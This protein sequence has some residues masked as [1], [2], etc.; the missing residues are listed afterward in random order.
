M[1]TRTV[2]GF[3]SSLAAA[4]LL[5]SIAFAAEIPAFP[6]AEGF[7]SRTPGGRGG[8]VF[9]VT[10]LN[11]AGPGSFRT[12]CE[13]KGP[14]IVVFRVSGLIDLKTPV[15]IAEPNITIAGQ[16][17]PGDGVCLR[18][19]GLIIES[20][21]VVVRYLRSRPG[22]IGGGEPDAMSIGGDS[23]NVVIDHCSASWATDENLSP[24]GGIAGVTVQ[25]CLIA[26]GLNHNLHHKGAHGYGSLCRAIGGISLH[27][28]LW[29]HNHGRNPRIGDNYGKPPYPTYDI[30]NNVMYNFGALSVVGDTLSANYVANYWKPGPNSSL[31]PRARLGPTNTAALKFFVQGNFVP[32]H[33]EFTNDAKSLFSR[34]EREGRKLVEIVP[35][36]FD[37]P[38]V[39]ATSA[40][41]A[42]DQVLASAGAVLPARDAVDRRIVT[43]VRN[44]TGAI[45][46]SQWEVGGWPEYKSTRPPRD[47]DRDGMPDDWEIAHGL[48]PHDPSDSAQDRDG[49]GYTNVEDYINSLCAE[50]VE[51]KE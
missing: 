41:K 30:R 11:D 2:P 5:S 43:E 50:G 8:K 24:S 26:E 51:G 12:A 1:I 38:P 25:W 44:G 48:N 17:A 31:E 6:G 37:T 4:C 42:Y 23:R 45:I 47:S 32:G 40:L 9:L 46:D 39:Q 35:K 28:N 29:A 27:H 18:G 34:T 7:G 33:P 15:R 3:T 21:D 36:P 10:N 49:N 20:H 13:G 16:T 22:D 14:R 19:R